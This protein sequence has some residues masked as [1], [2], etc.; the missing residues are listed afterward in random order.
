VLGLLDG[1]TSREAIAKE[2][3]PPLKVREDVQK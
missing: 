3:S 1:H 2:R